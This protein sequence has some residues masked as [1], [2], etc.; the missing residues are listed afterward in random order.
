M[1]LPT[2]SIVEELQRRFPLQFE[3]AMLTVINRGLEN[4]V[5]ELEAL[6][7]SSEPVST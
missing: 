5:A 1:E 6:A 7:K 2:D 4:R 3:V